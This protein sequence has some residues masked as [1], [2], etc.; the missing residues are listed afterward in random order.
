MLDRVVAI[1]R[2]VA[3][4][5]ALVGIT[6]WCAADLRQ[7]LTVLLM[8]VTVPPLTLLVKTVVEGALVFI[9]DRLHAGDSP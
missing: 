1:V 4:S 6:A 8:V 3:L 7:G 2:I 9:D 5:V